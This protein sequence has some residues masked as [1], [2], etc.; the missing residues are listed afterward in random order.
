MGVSSLLELLP[1]Y[2]IVKSTGGPP[3]DGVPFLGCPRQHPSEKHK[4][5]LIY[6]PLGENAKL[7][8]FKIEDV[9]YV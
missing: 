1:L 9:L 6:N 3:K 2:D 5:I 8:E 7:M 4:L